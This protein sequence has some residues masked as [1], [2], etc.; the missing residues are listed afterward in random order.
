MRGPEA[1]HTNEALSPVASFMPVNGLHD[2]SG[3]VWEWTASEQLSG[4]GAW[5]NIRGASYRQ[6]VE[7]SSSTFRLFYGRQSYVSS[8]VGFRV[9]RRDIAQVALGRVIGTSSNL[10]ASPSSGL[11]RGFDSPTEDYALATMEVSNSDFSA[12]LNDKLASDEIELVNDWVLSKDP[13]M[14]FGKRL[15]LLDGNTGIQF[16]SDQFVPVLGQ[17]GQPVTS[18]SWFGSDGFCQWLSKR[19]E[20]WSF[21]LP[22]EW[23]WE[24]A[25]R[26]GQLGQEASLIRGQLSSDRG[27]GDSFSGAPSWSINGMVSSAAEWTGTAVIAQPEFMIIRG[28][29]EHWHTGVRNEA[30]RVE[31]MKADTAA[32]TLGFRVVRV[33]KDD[34]KAT[35]SN[36]MW[37]AAIEPGVIE[38]GG[39]GVLI[40]TRL[41]DPVFAQQLSVAVN[42]PRVLV[43]SLVSFA[44]GESVKLV[45]FE[46]A[47]DMLT[48]GN[49]SVTVQ[50]QS[51][52]SSQA[53]LTVLVRD[54]SIP[55]L[56]VAVVA[57]E[58]KSGET[59]TLRITRSGNKAIALPV[60][61]GGDAI[62]GLG[63]PNTITLPEGEEFTDYQLVLPTVAAESTYLLEASAD[64]YS[65]TEEELRVEPGD[66]G[67]AYD[68]WTASAGLIG[69]DSEP[70]ATPMGDGVT[71]LLKF[72]F[73]MDGTQVDQSHLAYGLS[74]TSGLPAMALINV[75]EGK[76][77]SVEYVRR[78]AST[79]PGVV[80]TVEFGSKL[81][82]W[83][84]STASEEITSI[85]DLWERVIV[86]DVVPVG[87]VPRFGRVKVGLSP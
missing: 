64:W 61:L 39:Q 41:G 66:S 72:A 21:R 10:I 81:D 51:E 82:D 32:S 4:H 69:T 35:S 56:S 87:S 14:H 5:K 29:V 31:Y 38:E 17:E 65:P 79:N 86:N 49:S 20:D 57:G 62:T 44:P 46:V 19:S 8:E 12:F 59:V 42:D 80:Y 52:N 71:N 13:A 2:L 77:L 85:D 84:S 53:S 43:P 33:T 75:G 76:V 25:S 40:L 3:N 55:S 73:N 83:V 9:I 58:L 28:G 27:I 6:P 45:A 23:E 11:V 60:G 54:N 68:V 18:V 24:L 50:I 7:S 30:S 34:W 37:N 22:T 48:Q 63:M 70:I 36:G 47:P 15:L 16:V 74:K 1:G 67:R 26:S 78:K